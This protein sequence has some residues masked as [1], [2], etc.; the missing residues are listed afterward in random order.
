MEV[1]GH[2]APHAGAPHAE[3]EHASHGSH[4]DSG[5]PEAWGWHHEFTAGRQIGGW[6]SFLILAAL[7]VTTHYN[8]AGSLAIIVVMVLLAGGL[9]WDRQRRRN[10]WRS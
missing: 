3:V 7:L 9:I 2:E 10:Q 6:L 5:R 8:H 4:D 1:S